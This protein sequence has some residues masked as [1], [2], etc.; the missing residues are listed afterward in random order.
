MN[1]LVCGLHFV[2]LSITSE[3]WVGRC[4]G[5][6][7]QIAPLGCPNSAILLNLSNLLLRKL[8]DSNPR[9]GY[10]YVSLANWWFQP[11]TQTSFLRGSWRIR[12]AVHGFAD[13]W[14]S[15]SSKEPIFQFS[16]HRLFLDCGCKGTTIFWICKRFNEKFRWNRYFFSF[17]HVFSRV[18]HPHGHP[19]QGF[20]P[21]LIRLKQ[22]IVRLIIHTMQTKRT[23]PTIISWK[24]MNNLRFKW[25]YDVL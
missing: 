4:K 3:G 18:L 13:R 16:L 6:K 10:P 8:G 24:F 22:R 23:I 1:V 15:H 9:Y 19:S 11:L 2:Q 5:Y 20:I 21:Y 14:L 7:T 25:K 12:T 17:G